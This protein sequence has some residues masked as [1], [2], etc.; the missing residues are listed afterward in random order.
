MRN[1]LAVLAGIGVGAALMYL[2]DPQ[3][4]NRRRS[5]LRDKA[6]A[7]KNDAG[8]AI[9]GKAEHLSNRAKG[10]IYEAKSAFG[11]HRENISEPTI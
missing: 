9:T 2:L 3:G 1:I 4:G 7:F 8:E 5:L 11:R 10:L 6:T